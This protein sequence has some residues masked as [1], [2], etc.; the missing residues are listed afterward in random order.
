MTMF[1]TPAVLPCF[2]ALYFYLPKNLFPKNMMVTV[3]NF[4]MIYSKLKMNCYK[5]LL[6]LNLNR[7]DTEEMCFLHRIRQKCEK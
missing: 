6:S 7:K 1:L 5:P 3:K 4:N 2:Y